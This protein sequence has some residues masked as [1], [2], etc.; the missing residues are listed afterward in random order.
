MEKRHNYDVIALLSGGLDSILAARLVQ[1]QGKRVLCL[2]FVTPF[3][4]KPN[5][6]DKWKAVYGLEVL[7]VDVSGAFVDM[8]RQGPAHGF[9]KV[10]NPCVDCK[11]MLLRMAREMMP[12]FGAKAIITGE[13]LGQRPMSQ[14]KD[15]LDIIRREAGVSDVLLRPL[16]AQLLP[17]IPAESSGFIDRSRLKAF[18]GRG[19]KEQLALAAAF[20]ITDIPTPAGGCLLTEQGTSRAYWPLLRL[21]PEPRPDDFRLVKAGRQFWRREK[22]L[23]WLTVGRTEK[24]NAKLENLASEHDLLFS[25]EDFTGPVALGRNTADGAWDD[26]DL[27]CT[28]AAHTASFSGKAAAY[29]AET[30]KNV[31]VRIRHTGGNGEHRLLVKP[32]RG[33]GGWAEFPWDYA[34]E[35][36]KRESRQAEARR[37]Q[38]RRLR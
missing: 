32:E 17:E 31:A 25:L 8:L 30:G 20:G 5:L 19:R 11:I 26:P 23:G 1:E 15:A 27:V 21:W 6:T 2:H 9:G 37:K 34:R 16:S 10:L 22:K 24:D 28:A 35:E 14:R 33:A 4:G 13:V 36:I 7:P 12:R 38:E 29:A 18:S 3:F